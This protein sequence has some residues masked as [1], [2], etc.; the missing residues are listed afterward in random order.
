M[1]LNNN[2]TMELIVLSV[3][4]DTFAVVPDQNSP[5]IRVRADKPDLMDININTNTFIDRKNGLDF[6]E[7]ITHRVSY[8]N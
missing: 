5:G 8:T 7:F 6:S 3:S 1:I 2:Q 4:A